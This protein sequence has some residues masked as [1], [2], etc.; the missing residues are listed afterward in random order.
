V[1]QYLVKADPRVRRDGRRRTM[2]LVSAG[3]VATLYAVHVAALSG[4]GD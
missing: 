1:K 3:S 4:P 2:P